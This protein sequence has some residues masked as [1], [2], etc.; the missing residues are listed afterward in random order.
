MVVSD[1]FIT[2]AHKTYNWL[3]KKI[4]CLMATMLL[5]VANANAVLKEKDLENTLTIL[6]SEL[7]ATHRNLTAQAAMQK[8]QGEKMRGQILSVLQN[9]NRNALMLYSQKE[10]YLF[11]LTYACHEATEQ[12]HSFSKMKV[13]FDAYLKSTTQEIARYDSLILSL[14]N[15][16][17]MVLSSKSRNDRNVCLTLATSI[18]NNLAENYESTEEFISIYGMVETHLR[19]INDY[20]NSRYGDIQTSIFKNGDE[21]YFSLISSFHRTIH[22]A[23]QT[24]GSKYKSNGKSQWDSRI[25]FGLFLIIFFYGVIAAGLNLVAFRFFIPSK[26]KTQDFMSK[27]SSIIMATTTVTFALIVGIVR[28]TVKQNF[29]VMASDL[30]VEY[31]WL[32]GVILLSLLLRLNANQI[33]AALKIYSP[34]ILVGFIV[35][36]FRIILIPNELVNILFPPIL[37]ICLVWQWFTVR[38]HNKNI[39]Q[40]DMFYTYT[41]LLVLLVSVVCSW[42]GYT[43]MSVQALIWWIMQLTCILTIACLDR[44]ITLYADT[45]NLHNK[46]ATETWIYYLL[47][48]ALLPVL[49][50][51]S[52]MISIYWAAKVFNLN[53]TCWYIFSADFVNFENLKLSIVRLATVISLWFIFNYISKTTKAMLR[54][55]FEMRDPSSADSKMMMAKNIIQVAVWGIWFLVALS[56]LGISFAWLLVVTG[57]LS[58]G[59]GF[60]SKDIIENIY[61][62]ISLMT[63]RIKV[64]DLIEC[65]GVRGK[66]ASI[67]YTSTLIEALDGSVIAFQNSQLFANNF[68]NL[69]RNHGYALSSIIFGVGYGSNFRQVATMVE[70]AVNEMHHTG[71]DPTKPVKVLFVEFGDNS[72]NL[73]IISWVEV[74]RQGAIES[75][76][77]DCIYN[78]LNANGIEIPFPKRDV[79]IKE[80]PTS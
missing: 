70:N 28:A 29:I 43:L 6:R 30:L 22:Q 3:M 40:S 62:G 8:E 34:L 61:Y 17:L 64:G 11:D 9:S 14:K 56:T 38:R 32:L 4:L 77:K 80:T 47:K 53:D 55:H 73:K 5:V 46:A 65:D 60:A 71:I 10:D 67:S 50:V 2:F 31:A 26:V 12:Y 51:L 23:T 7:T 57:G 58:T 63:G 69:T 76:I 21:D 75:D 59:I 66:V 24:V 79:Y 36:V 39:P 72:V 42:S 78:T 41:S 35:I 19:N 16:P 27:R 52:V 33:K 25:I 68:K 1:I 13:P 18:R 48:Q 15:M 37:L 49:A 74:L 45:H 20:A 54:I 44:W